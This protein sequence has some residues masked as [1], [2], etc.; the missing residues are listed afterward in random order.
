MKLNKKNSKN[1][2]DKMYQKF[3][4]KWEEVTELPT[5]EVGSLTPLFKRTVP[6]FKVAPWRVL[7]PLSFLLVA[8]TALFFEQTAAQVASILQRGF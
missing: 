6:Y 4:A 1:P 8:S 2:S 5:Q 7:L 3:L